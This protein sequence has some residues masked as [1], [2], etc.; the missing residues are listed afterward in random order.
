MTASLVLPR[1]EPETTGRLT[2]GLLASALLHLALLVSFAPTTPRFSLPTPFQVEIQP[3]PGRA[4]EIEPGP[5]SREP[6]GEITIPQPSELA[7]PPA[8]L[9]PP[10]KPEPPPA[11]VAVAPP[12]PIEAPLPLDKYFTAREVDVRAEPLNEVDLVYPKRAY[13]H[14]TRGQVRLT[15]YINQD[16]ELD[17][18]DVVHAVPPGVFEEAA[19]E[20]ARALRFSPAT[21]WGRPVKSVKTIEVTFDPYEK[22]TTP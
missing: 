16:G 11:P 6:K 3:S 20:A 4:V 21:K 22:I 17:K 9:A 14:R 18:V 13:Q 19:L 7:G 12:A 8:E 2:L 5:E 1:Q 15:L 10:R